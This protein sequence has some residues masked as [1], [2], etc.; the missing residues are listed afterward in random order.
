MNVI[1]IFKSIEGEGKRTGYLSTFI[2]FAGCNLRCNYCD[3]KYSY[4]VDNS[5]QL[6]VKQIVNKCKSLGTKRVTLT[7]GEPLLQED[8]VLLVEE[9]IKEE[10]EI[11][12]ETNGS[13]D[14]RKWL[15]YRKKN[16][17]FTI[18]YKCISSGMNGKMLL[19]NFKLLD[20]NDVLKFVV[21]NKD[22]LNEMRLFIRENGASKC[23]IY[24]SPVWGAIDA[25]DIVEYLKRHNLY[26]CR[27]QLQLHKIIWS[28]DTRGV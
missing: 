18:D 14:I 3:T 8:I 24:V 9:L 27:L 22:D 25:K 5:Q 17:F 12:I 28:P 20:D 6:D 19:S 16:L 4:D 11:N 10:Y 1:E 23:K 2:R 15:E 26:N 7:G 13:V 21:Q